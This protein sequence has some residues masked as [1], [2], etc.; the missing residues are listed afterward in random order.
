[1][2]NDIKSMS[3]AELHQLAMEKGPN[4]N[5]SKRALEAQWE[6]VRR[7]D[8]WGLV[9]TESHRRTMEL[10]KGARK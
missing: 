10:M 6:I 4:G 9:M 1:M 5:A 8:G 2:T 7:S 3:D